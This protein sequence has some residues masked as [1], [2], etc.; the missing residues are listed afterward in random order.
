M[1]EG[2]SQGMLEF[3][4]RDLPAIMS[5]YGTSRKAVQ[6]IWGDPFG[7]YPGRGRTMMLAMIRRTNTTKAITVYPLSA[8]DYNNGCSL[9]LGQSRQIQP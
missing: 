6:S 2:S 8:I 5:M 3:G 7:L 4:G 9:Y 1:P